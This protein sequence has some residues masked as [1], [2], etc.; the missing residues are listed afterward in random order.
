MVVRVIEKLE[1]VNFNGVVLDAIERKVAYMRH[2]HRKF[3]NV[4]M[5]TL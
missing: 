1:K 4:E 5:S 3:S 2:Y